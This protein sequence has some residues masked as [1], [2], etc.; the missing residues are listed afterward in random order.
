[1][2]KV[3]WTG[4]VS[5]DE[6]GAPTVPGPQHDIDFMLKDSKRFADSG[7][8]GYGAFEYDAASNTYRLGNLKTSHR[9]GTTP[10]AGSRAIRQ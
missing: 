5:A 8:W 4:K 3:H 1:M 7:G 9:K 6:P 2:A 10:N